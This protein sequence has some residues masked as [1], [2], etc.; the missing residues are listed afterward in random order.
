MVLLDWGE[1]R[2]ERLG[3]DDQLPRMNA[4]RGDRRSALIEL[5][6]LAV[7]VGVDL[8]WLRTLPWVYPAALA[9]VVIIAIVVTS[10]RRRRGLQVAPPPRV[11]SRRAWGEV[12]AFT[13]LVVA[14]LVLLGM[15]LRTEPYDEV[16]LFALRWPLRDQLALVVVALGRASIQQLI[17]LGFLAPTSQ[18]I[19]TP[20][21]RADLLAAAFFGAAHLPN[22]FLAGG[23]LL[24]GWM[25]IW[26]F[27]RGRRVGPVLASHLLLAGCAFA[28]FPERTLNDLHVGAKA[29][30]RAQRYEAFERDETRRKLRWICSFD[31]SAAIEGDDLGSTALLL[32]KLLGR[33]ATARELDR[34]AYRTERLSRCSAAKKLLM[35]APPPGQSGA[36]NPG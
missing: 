12:G 8:W 15:A 23:T 10:F 17:L 21:V 34:W 5:S 4:A 11:D 2:Y 16:R 14:L 3:T 28:L 13:L 7:A 20:G 31:D 27:R 29:V 19:L 18:E 30:A 24:A 6:T 32:E 35:S 26:L 1:R 36:G 22:L 25:W 9:Q 33:P